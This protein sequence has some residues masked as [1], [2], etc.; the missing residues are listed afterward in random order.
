[1]CRVTRIDLTPQ[2]E[3]EPQSE[4]GSPYSGHPPVV[5]E[6]LL[7]SLDGPLGEDPDAVVAVHHHH[8]TAEQQGS[9]VVRISE[10]TGSVEKSSPLTFCIAVGVDGVIGKADL[11]A[12]PGGVNHKV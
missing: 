1:M 5:E 4:S 8:C 11:V 6:E 7:S 3:A 9:T 12:F 10:P 2:P